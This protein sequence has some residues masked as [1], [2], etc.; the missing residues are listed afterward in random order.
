MPGS[1]S[2]NSIGL[3]APLKDWLAD[4]QV[5]E[6]SIN[7]PGEVFVDRCGYFKRYARPLLTEAWLRNVGQLLANEHKKPFD[8]TAPLLSAELSDGAR[9]YAILPPIA[10]YP[11]MTIRCQTQ[12]TCRLQAYPYRGLSD[13]GPKPVGEHAHRVSESLREQSSLSRLYANHDW[14]AWIRAA[15]LAHKNIVISGATASGKTSFLNACLHEI[16]LDERVITL[17]DVRELQV[18]H[19][20]Q[21]SLLAHE[22]AEFSISMQQLLR[23]ALRLRPDRIIMGE[24]RGQEV[25]DFVSACLTGHRGSMATI[26]AGSPHQALSRMAQLYQQDMAMAGFSREAIDALLKSAIDGIVQ[27][28]RDGHHYTIDKVYWRG[29]ES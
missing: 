3:L 29:A 14:H 26:H 25:V 5:R 2:P 22:Q 17:E 11:L 23:S 27:L 8:T 18:P 10:R 13:G 28:H 20:N 6:I 24:M 4:Q 15:I 9:V 19:A 1:F 12:V 7:Q 16:P 21:V